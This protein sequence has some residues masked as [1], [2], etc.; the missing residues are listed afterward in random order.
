MIKRQ[1]YQT[2]RSSPTVVACR[3]YMKT[4]ADAG[5]APPVPPFH[6]R[7]ELPSPSP[8]PQPAPSTSPN[9]HD[10]PTWGPGYVTQ[11][12]S[13][14]LTYGSPTL[15]APKVPT[16]VDPGSPFALLP[17]DVMSAF[18]THLPKPLAHHFFLVRQPAL[19]VREPVLRLLTQLRKQTPV[20]LDGA[21]RVG[22]SSTLLQAVSHHYSLGALVVYIPHASSWIAGTAPFIH[23]PTTGLYDQPRLAADIIRQILHVN[24]KRLEN[25]PQLESLLKQAARHPETAHDAL[26]TFLLDDAKP[27]TLVAIDQVN[28]LWAHST[29]YRNTR[30]EAIP[31]RA[32]RIVRTFE[33]LFSGSSKGNTLVVAATDKSNPRIASGCTHLLAETAS[34]DAAALSYTRTEVPSLTKL[35]TR[36][37][38]EHLIDV[39]AVFK[40]NLS[41]SEALL[42]KL[43][44]VSCGNVG[45]IVNDLTRSEAVSNAIVTA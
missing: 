39:R 15:A 18:H 42:N 24:H 9:R 33:K 25:H 35:E 27:D 5:R 19:L 14:K 20:L 8:L 28:A 44:A 23:N 2:V 31:A 40:T 26:D 29:L 12:K 21:A 10:L 16:G 1:A 36:K 41:Y 34:A 6:T 32:F 7:K 43:Y 37:L 11:M 13:Q 38:I 45:R 17:D 4:T 22:K 3:R 30:S